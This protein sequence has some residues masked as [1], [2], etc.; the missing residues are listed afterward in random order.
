MQRNYIT[1]GRVQTNMIYI[2]QYAQTTFGG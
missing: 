1:T 2:F